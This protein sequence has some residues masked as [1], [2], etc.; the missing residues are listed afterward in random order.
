MAYFA[1]GILVIGAWV[2]AIVFIGS[3]SMNGSVNASYDSQLKDVVWSTETTWFVW[4]T[5]FSI[6]WLISFIICCNE[7]VIIVAA[8]TWYF[9]RKDIPD[10]DGIPGDSEVCKGYTWSMRYHLG[11]ISLGSFILMFVWMVRHI[12]EYIGHRLQDATGENCC[13]KCLLCCCLCCLSC[14]D[15]FIRYL[16]ENAF[17]YQAISCEGFCSSAIHSFL[18]MLKNSVKFSMVDGLA[19]VFIFIAKCLISVT[20]TWI[21]YLLLGVMVED[22]IHSTFVPLLIIFLVS[23]MTSAIF[24]GILEV[25]SNTILQCYLIDKE[26]SE[27]GGV[28]SQHVPKRLLK[29]MK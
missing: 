22:D 20:V 29:F 26:L 5:F 3:V 11:S 27:H 21:S 24:V 28:D 18:L 8:C 23:Y 19:S 4:L 15:R 9:S 25:G 12:F 2:S 7:F 1:L 14:F 17:I 13:T 10:D 6:F 16:T